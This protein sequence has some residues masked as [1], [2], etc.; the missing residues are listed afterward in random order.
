ME[1]ARR[2]QNGRNTPL[3]QAARQRISIELIRRA[4]TY[5]L[6]KQHD[7][8]TKITENALVHPSIPKEDIINIAD[9]ATGTG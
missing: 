5:R 6:D 8:L 2:S 4:A 9:I 3:S 7:L 1:E